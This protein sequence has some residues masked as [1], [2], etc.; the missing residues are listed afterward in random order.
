MQSAN[1]AQRL[2]VRKD[3]P[4]ELGSKFSR[5]PPGPAP[6][7]IPPVPGPGLVNATSQRLSGVARID[8]STGDHAISASACLQGCSGEHTEDGPAHPHSAPLVS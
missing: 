1:G 2:C 5:V 6:V 4:P 8:G 3:T 7:E